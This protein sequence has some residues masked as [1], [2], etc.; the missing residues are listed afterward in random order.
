MSTGAGETVFEKRSALAGPVVNNPAGLFKSLETTAHFGLA[1]R[2]FCGRQI[3]Q[4]AV[5]PV[6]IVFDS[7]LLQNGS[8]FFRCGGRKNPTSSLIWVAGLDVFGGCPPPGAAFAVGACCPPP[9]LGANPVAL[10]WVFP[11]CLYV[12]TAP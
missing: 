10:A 12:A 8:G 6:L 1:G 7:P 4:R 3:A 9:L 2:K 11:A 5:R